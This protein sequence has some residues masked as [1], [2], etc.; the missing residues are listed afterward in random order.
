MSVDLIN[1]LSRMD[2]FQVG[3]IQHGLVQ[4]VRPKAIVTTFIRKKELVLFA[5]VGGVYFFPIIF[6][7]LKWLGWFLSVPLGGRGWSYPLI[8]STTTEVKCGKNYLGGWD[9]WRQIWKDALYLTGVVCIMKILIL[10]NGKVVGTVEFK[11]MWKMS[12]FYSSACSHL[13]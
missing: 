1:Y 11:V 7:P 2:G 3:R 5:A 9:K 6:G 12:A 13:G 8:E 10:K 4:W